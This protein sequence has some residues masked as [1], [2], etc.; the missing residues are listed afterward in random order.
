ME[1]HKGLDQ[2]SSCEKHMWKW[3]YMNLQNVRLPAVDDTTVFFESRETFT[4]AI[5]SEKQGNKN[6]KM[7]IE[8][9]GEGGFMKKMMNGQDR[10]LHERKVVCCIEGLHETNIKCFI[11]LQV[12]TPGG[13]ASRL[14]KSSEACWKKDLCESSWIFQSH[15]QTFFLKFSLECV[16]IR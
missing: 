8:E 12:A 13:T 9:E 5:L 10:N 3:R 14:L 2:C 15:T 7:N 11:L 6:T 16:M 1:C 4:T